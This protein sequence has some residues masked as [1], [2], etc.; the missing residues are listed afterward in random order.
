MKVNIPIIK[1][2]IL[3]SKTFDSDLLV[4]FIITLYRFLVVR[5]ESPEVFV[6]TIIE[7]RVA[8]F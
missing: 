4:M 1:K 3:R 7:S 6:D 8:T 5:S 2:C